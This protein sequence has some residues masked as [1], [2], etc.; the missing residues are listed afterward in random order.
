[1]GGIYRPGGFQA[2]L[3]DIETTTNDARIWD[4][5]VDGETSSK[6]MDIVKEVIG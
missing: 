5:V 1:V 6:C 4:G 2:F 3:E